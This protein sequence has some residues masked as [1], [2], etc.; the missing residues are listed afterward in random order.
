[1]MVHWPEMW[2]ESSVNVQWTDTLGG[3]LQMDWHCKEGTAG[4]FATKRRLI[5]PNVRL[6][7]HTVVN[8]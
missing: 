7:G 3:V 2:G 1:M 4:V 5:E 6:C 8:K